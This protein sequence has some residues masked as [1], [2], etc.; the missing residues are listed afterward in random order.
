[1]RELKRAGDLHERTAQRKR[2]EK[3]LFE[4]AGIKAHL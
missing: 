2:K 4:R 1:M 3:L